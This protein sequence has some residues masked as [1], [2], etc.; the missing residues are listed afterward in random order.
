MYVYIYI[1]LENIKD[2]LQT[3]PLQFFVTKLEL[4]VYSGCPRG[5]SVKAMDCR[6]VVSE[7]VLHS[8]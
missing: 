2:K 8:R 5:V 7:F 4:T 3:S 6:I 1:V